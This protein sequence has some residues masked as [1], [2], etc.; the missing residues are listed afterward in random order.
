MIKQEGDK[1]KQIEK[2]VRVLSVSS[3]HCLEFTACQLAE[4]PHPL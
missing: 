2:K 1:V 3:P 4:S